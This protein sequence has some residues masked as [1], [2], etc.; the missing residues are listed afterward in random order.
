MQNKVECFYYVRLT[1]G[2]REASLI[3]MTW[4]NAYPI[5]VMYTVGTGAIITF[6]RMFLSNEIITGIKLC[7]A[8]GTFWTVHLGQGQ[9]SNFC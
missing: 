5:L 3:C 6:F 8:M 4:H 2:K 1:G 9:T 7:E